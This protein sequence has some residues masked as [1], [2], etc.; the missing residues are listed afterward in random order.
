MFHKRKKNNSFAKFILAIKTLRNIVLC[1]L[2]FINFSCAKDGCIIHVVDPIKKDTRPIVYF[3][4]KKGSLGDIGYVDALYRG[5]VSST[6]ENGMMLSLVELPTDEE[7]IETALTYMIEYMQDEGKNRRALVV[8][9]N[10]NLEALLRKYKD[11]IIQADNVDFLLT[12]SIDTTLPIHTM[13]I[14]QYGVYYQAGKIAGQCLENINDALVVYAN[15]NELSLLD[16]GLGFR[17]GIDNSGKDID[18][19][20]TYI[21]DAYGGYD[22]ADYAY[23]FSYEID[24]SYELV[25]PLCG[26]TC[27]GFFRY[28]RENPGKFYT[29]GVDSDMQHYSPD[30]PF[31]I[32]K[33]ID[34]A[35]EMWITRWG[36][37]ETMPEHL[38]LGLSSGYT[39]IVVSDSYADKG[40]ADIATECYQDALKKE[41]EYEKL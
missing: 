14:P 39:E 28:N 29:L 34:E 33:H 11:K 13:R 20:E 31:S 16:M 18:L 15:S 9:A 25:L 37:G 3:V 12:E 26:G 8:I 35:V 21:T 22:E 1:L 6:N 32:V 23:K 17:D 7:S 27:Q 36:K 41:E 19:I 38:S 4:S 30:V 40:L 5:V 2:L 10:D 24:G